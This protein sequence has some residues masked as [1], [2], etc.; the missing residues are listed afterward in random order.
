MAEP[1]ADPRLKPG[2]GVGLTA[3]FARN[4]TLTTLSVGFRML[5]KGPVRIF[6]ELPPPPCVVAF[7][8]NAPVDAFALGQASRK[9]GHIP[10]AL[11]KDS[12][13]KAPGLGWIVRN[14]GMV[15]VIRDDVGGRD[16]AMLVSLEHLRRGHTLFVAPAGTIVASQEV[17]E[18]RYRPGAARLAVEVGVPIVAAVVLGP[19]RWGGHRRPFRPR[20]N[21]P[22]D[23]HYGQ[24]FNA[25]GEPRDV[26]PRMAAAVRELLDQAYAVYPEPGIGQWWWPLRLGG[27]APPIPVEQQD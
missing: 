10:I 2:T 24:P 12:L 26:V 9:A 11:V 7:H 16:Q 13:F 20:P 22:I 17:E 8:H 15:P 4:T 18:E 6:G 3:R 5:S 23:I 27:S 25:S 21:T 19:H 14:A 1:T